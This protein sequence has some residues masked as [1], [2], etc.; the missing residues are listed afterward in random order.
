MA[1][2]FIVNSKYDADYTVFFVSS[3]YDE[4]NADIIKNGKLVN[5]KYDADVK[6]FI[7]KSKYDAKILITHE[8]FPK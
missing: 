1:K 2:V 8:N 3:K 4:K 5:S 6:V 7:V